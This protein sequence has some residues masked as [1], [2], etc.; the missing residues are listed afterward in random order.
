MK[1]FSGFNLIFRSGDKPGNSPLGV[2]TLT[3]INGSSLISTASGFS[4]KTICLTHLL[5]FASLTYY[6]LP[7][8]PIAK[9]MFQSIQIFIPCFLQASCTSIGCSVTG[10]S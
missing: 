7:H 8:A 2:G 1:D 5:P 3:N 4:M 9:V 10:V 6:H